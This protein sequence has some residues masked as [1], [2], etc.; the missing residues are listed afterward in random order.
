MARCGTVD[1][2]GAGCGPCQVQSL[3]V[4]KPDPDNQPSQ[5]HPAPRIESNS[6]PVPTV[7]VLSTVLQCALTPAPI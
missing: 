1:P 5:P 7:D 6:V 4:P 3:Q 2:L